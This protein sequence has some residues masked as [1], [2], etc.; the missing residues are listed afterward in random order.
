MQVE[1]LCGL[2]QT[3][4]LKQP[5]NIVGCFCVLQACSPAVMAGHWTCFCSEKTRKCLTPLPLREWRFPDCRYSQ[6]TS[7]K[8]W[9]H[10]QILNYSNANASHC[11]NDV[12]TGNKLSWFLKYIDLRTFSL[13][14]ALTDAGQGLTEVGGGRASSVS[15]N[16]RPVGA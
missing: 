13:G 6:Q 10:L 15:A 8:C 7:R 1:M 5:D 2:A 9:K 12:T 16:A 14:C 3:K 11:G 4:H